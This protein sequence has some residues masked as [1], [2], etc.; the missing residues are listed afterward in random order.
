MARKKKETRKYTPRNE[1]RYNDSPLAEGHPHY[2]FG[3]K[4]GKYKSLGLTTSP[5]EGI[6]HVKLSKNPEPN[7]QNDSYLQMRVHT[8][9]KKYYDEPLK[10]W[11]FAKEDKPIVRHRIKEYKKS[12]NR[13]PKGWFEKKRKFKDK[14]NKK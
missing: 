10:D 2:V 1:F 5:V 7:N 14:K 12:T 4:N 9:K 8:A 6:R 11:E 13:K 3:E